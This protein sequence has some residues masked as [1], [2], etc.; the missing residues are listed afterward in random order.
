[1]L[2]QS[3]LSYTPHQTSLKQIQ[4]ATYFHWCMFHQVQRL[5]KGK[6]FCGEF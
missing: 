5:L 1:M 4:D 3:H 2:T 6:E